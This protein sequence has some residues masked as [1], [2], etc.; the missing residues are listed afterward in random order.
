MVI[1]IGKNGK[2]C[3]WCARRESGLCTR[4]YKKLNIKYQKD[5]AKGFEKIP[6]DKEQLIDTL[7]KHSVH[8]SGP[9]DK[10]SDKDKHKLFEIY[11][12]CVEEEKASLKVN[13]ETPWYKKILNFFKK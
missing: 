12:E 13:L 8:I 7:H 11:K 3:K 10:I 6:H 1:H 4:H 2:Q 5:I 9:L